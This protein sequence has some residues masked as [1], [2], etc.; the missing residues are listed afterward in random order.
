M[1]TKTLSCLGVLATVI[2]LTTA[3]RAHAQE[4]PQRGEE[5]PSPQTSPTPPTTPVPRSFQD[6]DRNADG[7]ISKDEAAVD[8][9]LA[10]VFGTLDQDA[11]GRL[12]S[13]EYAVHARPDNP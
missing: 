13:E 10:Q 12:T 2:A 6:L 7:A 8:P 1:N 11:D 3:P 9:P 5:R 4:V